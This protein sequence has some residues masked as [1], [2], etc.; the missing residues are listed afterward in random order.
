MKDKLAGLVGML[1]LPLIVVGGLAGIICFMLK[2]GWS[3]AW[4]GCFALYDIK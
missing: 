1:G 3:M 2:T 4:D